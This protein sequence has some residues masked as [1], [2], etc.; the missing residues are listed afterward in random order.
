MLPLPLQK[1]KN[2][3][4]K[5]SERKKG[6]KNILKNRKELTNDKEKSTPISNNL[7]C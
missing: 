7:E 5:Q 6:T 3:N 2:C 4:N 1:P